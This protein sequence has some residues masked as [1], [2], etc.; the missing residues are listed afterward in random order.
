M[1]WPTAL[2]FMPQSSN[3]Y[4]AAVVQWSIGF[5]SLETSYAKG[6]ID[7]PSSAMKV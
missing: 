6:W 7:D 4:G 3:W 5:L 1:P 2:C